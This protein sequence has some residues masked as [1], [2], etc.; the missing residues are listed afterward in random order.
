MLVATVHTSIINVGIM[1]G[2]AVSG[3]AIDADYGLAFPLWVGR[4]WGFLV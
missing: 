1:I 4:K 2:S 3:V